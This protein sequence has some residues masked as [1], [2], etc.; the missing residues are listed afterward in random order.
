MNV[1]PTSAKTPDPPVA[2]MADRTMTLDALDLFS[3]K[4][5]G[6]IQTLLGFDKHKEDG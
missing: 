3:Y 6:C 2:T 4:E 5:G 1:I